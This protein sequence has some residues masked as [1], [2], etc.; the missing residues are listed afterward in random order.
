[1][2]RTSPANLQD[3]QNEGRE[4]CKFALPLAGNMNRHVHA[5]GSARLSRQAEERICDCP[6]EFS[7]DA[8]VDG[9]P[10]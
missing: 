6:K 4:A 5:H 8:L 2:A 9:P 10:Q 1:M 7:G 3:G